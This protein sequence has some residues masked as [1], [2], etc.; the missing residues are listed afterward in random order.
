[1]RSIAEVVVLTT[2]LSLVLILLAVPSTPVLIYVWA[3]S[4]TPQAKTQVFQEAKVDYR[5]VRFNYDKSLAS[6][7]TAKIVEAQV[8]SAENSGP[9]DTI[10]P[11]HVAFELVGTYPPKPTSFIGSEI[12]VYPV[13]E[14]KQAFAPD[15]KA[16]REVSATIVRLQRILSTRDLAFKGEVPLLPLP[17]GYLAFRAHTAFLRFKQGSGMVFLTQGQQD[18]MPVNNQSLSY[19]FQGL[20]N[21]GRYYVTAEFP[22]AAPFLAYDRD[23][24]NYGGSVK[25]SSC[26]QCPDHA[27]F[28]REYRAYVRT[29]SNKLEKLPPD[30]FQPSLKLFDD[31]ITSIEVDGN[32]DRLMKQ[33]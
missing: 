32:A 26:Y 11:T 16:A 21:D 19:E 18:E 17:D 30:K 5:G 23:T 14:Y 27:R 24:A 28:M 13:R 29:I 1:M 4:N 33:Q 8:A 9:G 12:H 25:E 20:T 2:A 6:E 10:Y 31:L 7:V 22:V 3:E 15:P